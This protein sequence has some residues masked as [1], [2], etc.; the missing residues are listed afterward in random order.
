M[1]Y[2]IF[3]T[4]MAGKELLSHLKKENVVYFCDNDK[5]KVGRR[6]ED[7]EIISFERLKEISE[8][9]PIYIAMS[10]FAQAQVREQLE[11]AGI[12][13]YILYENDKKRE[14]K[15]RRK[16]DS[17]IDKL[18]LEM[19][20]RMKTIDPI[21]NFAEF[22]YLVKECK[23]RS[24]GKALYSTGQS[25]TELYGYGKALMDYA[26]LQC[27]YD[28][29][30]IVSHGV[31]VIY[32]G[33]LPRLLNFST[34]TIVFGNH[35]KKLHNSARPYVPIFSVGPYIK[36]ALPNYSTEKLNEMK[37]R[38]GKTAVVFLSHSIEEVNINYDES[39]I[40]RQL[41]DGYAKQYDTIIACIYWHDI[42]NE[43]CETL[44][45]N[46]IQIVSAGFRWDEQFVNRLKSI[47]TLADAVVF[48]GFTTA[49]I[50][51]IAMKKKIIYH[52]I[53]VKYDAE[54]SCKI[55]FETFEKKREK[56]R[57]KN[58]PLYLEGDTLKWN[59]NCL[60]EYYGLN[61]FKSKKE[62]N[63]IYRVCCDIWENCEMIE[64]SYPIG[65][66]RTYLNY[67]KKYEY[68][69]LTVLSRAMGQGAIII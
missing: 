11:Q 27:D 64:R 47:L 35:Y 61:I 9:Y 5:N 20:K 50:F 39:V 63:L 15:I 36:Y 66:Y 54:P 46:G 12:T 31:D 56:N 42:D 7:I 62:I 6:V 30:P 34:A 58:N 1:Q 52:D 10:S 24:E 28:K 14:P 17:E 55:F 59:D 51:A 44:Y 69:K 37:S 2:I 16:V 48:Y 8:I 40:L 67:Q 41:V 13:N 26:E 4:G 60:N 45:R 18:I 53:N 43:F 25:D 19:K 29:F 65:V 22:K 38:N 68:D 49:I 57:W 23:M 3:G 32:P 33:A 21:I